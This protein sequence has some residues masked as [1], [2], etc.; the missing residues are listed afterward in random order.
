MTEHVSF[1]LV[2]LT[3]ILLGSINDSISCGRDWCGIV[4]TLPGLLVARIPAV[5]ILILLYLHFAH[6]ID[7]PMLK[8]LSG[9]QYLTLLYVVAAG[10]SEVAVHFLLRHGTLSS[11]LPVPLNTIIT[12]KKVR[13]ADRLEKNVDA[14]RILTD[15][16]Q[17]SRELNGRKRA[18]EIKHLSTPP[19]RNQ[20]LRVIE[21]VGLSHFIALVKS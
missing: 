1:L 3:T 19:T 2:V 15:A 7:L 17:T 14:K 13:I 20:I 16:I 18:A 21:V 4:S 12:R 11:P 5:A 10:I 9:S 6:V 8:T